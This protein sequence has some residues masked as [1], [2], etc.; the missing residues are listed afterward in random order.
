MD[1][2]YTNTN[3][4]NTNYTNTNYTNTNYTNTNYTNTNYIDPGSSSLVVK[5]FS[6]ILL[7]ILLCAILGFVICFITICY[8]ECCNHWTRNLNNSISRDNLNNNNFDKIV[9]REEIDYIN[10]IERRNNLN[11]CNNSCPICLE[12]F[13]DND[14]D[15]D[16]T[17]SI[18]Y[19]ECKHRYHTDCIRE[20]YNKYNNKY[21]KKCPCPI[22][23]REITN[24]YM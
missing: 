18:C 17:Q 22:C 5:I 7:I 6:I 11:Y 15:N 10:N 14:N 16:N 4:T 8:E 21:G 9:I 23:K 3:Y 19:L 12:D 2:N 1:T 24:V 13:D 20:W